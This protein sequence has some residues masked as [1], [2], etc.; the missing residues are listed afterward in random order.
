[1]AKL[2]S[3][4]INRVLLCKLVHRKPKTPGLGKW[5]IEWLKTPDL[6]GYSLI[7][8]SECCLRGGSQDAADLVWR[9]RRFAL[10]DLR[11]HVTIT[12]V[13][14]NWAN[15]SVDWE[16]VAIRGVVAVGGCVVVCHETPLEERIGDEGNSINNVRRCKADRLGL[17][18]VVRRIPVKDHFP[19]R[20]RSV[21]FERNDLRDPSVSYATSK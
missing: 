11:L 6:A 7:N 21:H 12:V 2:E 14:V 20:Y 16:E 1:M 19:E 4:C 5:V 8:Y 10:E 3:V 13:V 18:K 9:T 17:G 15:W